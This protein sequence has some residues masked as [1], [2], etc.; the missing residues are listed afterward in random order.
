MQTKM[1][2][3]EL[4][5]I[6]EQTVMMPLYFLMA[7]SHDPFKSIDDGTQDGLQSGTLK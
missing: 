5:P 3:N 2:N 4:A 1:L 7:H 6:N